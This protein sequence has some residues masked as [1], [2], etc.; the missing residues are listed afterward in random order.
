MREREQEYALALHAHLTRVL[1]EKTAR[2]R[3]QEYDLAL[4]AH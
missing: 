4:R 1:S 3:E 2:E